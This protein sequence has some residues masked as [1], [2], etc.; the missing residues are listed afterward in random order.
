MFVGHID[1]IEKK[2]INSPELKGVLKQLAIGPEQG[3]EDHAMRIFTLKPGGHTPRHNH[4]WPHINYILKGK[5]TLYHGGQETQIRAGSIA[6]LPNGLEHQFVN[7][8]EQDL[9]FICIV[10]KEGDV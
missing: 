4:H 1:D 8:S 7:N 3:W 5:G 9:T 2:E 6:Y 10:P